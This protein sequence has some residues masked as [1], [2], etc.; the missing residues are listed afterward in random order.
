MASQGSGD[1]TAS[2]RAR[3]AAAYSPPSSMPR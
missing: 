3:D 1:Y 2:I